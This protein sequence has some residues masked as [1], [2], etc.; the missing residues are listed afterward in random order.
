MS[1]FIQYSHKSIIN[2]IKYRE[3]DFAVLSIG[4][5]LRDFEGFT[6]NFIKGTFKFPL[7]FVLPTVFID[8]EETG[9]MEQ[10]QIE[11]HIY[12]KS[13]WV[14][15]KVDSNAQLKLITE[16]CEWFAC[17]GFGSFMFQGEN[18]LYDDLYPDVHWDHPTEF[19]NL[20]W[21]KVAALIEIFEVGYTVITN[22]NK[23]NS[24]IKL[25]N[26]IPKEYEIDLEIKV[27]Q[28]RAGALT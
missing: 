28:P 19:P 4:V 5:M 6:Y 25:L 17:N 11:Y 16:Y 26:H 27:L 15:L 1:V 7:F 8:D 21:D 2:S 3:K 14:I 23:I 12:K 22:D 20:N 13:K 9:K 18:I 10:L 24:T